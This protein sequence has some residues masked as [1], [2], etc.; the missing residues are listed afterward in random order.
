MTLYKFE[1]SQPK[2]ADSNSSWLA[3][4]AVIIGNVELA[5]K[6]SVWFGAVLRGDNEPIIIQQGTNIQENTV[7]HT[8]PNFPVIV[9]QGC[10]IGHQATL[11][12]CTIRENSLI[13]MGA[14]ILN[15]AEIGKNSIVAAHSL[16]SEGKS[17]PD[18]SLILGTP[19]K[20]I[21]HLNDT[22]IAR[23]KRSAETYIQKISRYQ[24]GLIPLNHD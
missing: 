17:F 2:L 6:T 8:D 19:A 9:E 20:F 16:V 22:E 21:R 13:G 3:P 18:G 14:I 5:A 24:N 23:N 15:G 11:H 1:Q 4:E 7:I 10:T 12:G